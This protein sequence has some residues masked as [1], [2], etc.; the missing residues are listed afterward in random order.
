VADA[1]LYTVTIVS[2]VAALTMLTI[3]IVLQVSFVRKSHNQAARANG[4]LQDFSYMATAL[5]HLDPAIRCYLTSIAFLFI[6]AATGSLAV[7]TS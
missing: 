3:G 4:S 7:A 6:G 2:L 1:L 5:R